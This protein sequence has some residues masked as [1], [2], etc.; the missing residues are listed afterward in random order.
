MTRIDSRRSAVDL[1]R[2]LNALDESLRIEAK[3]CSKVDKSVM[4]TICVF[5]NEP[6]LGGGHLLLGVRRQEDHIN[7]I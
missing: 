6:R 5:A 2:E 1:L 7:G 4:E 3:T